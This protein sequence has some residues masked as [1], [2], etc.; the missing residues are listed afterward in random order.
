VYST[1]SRLPFQAGEAASGRIHLSRFRI[2]NAPDPPNPTAI[3]QAPS[4]PARTLRTAGPPP[5]S[6]GANRTFWPATL[7]SAVAPEKTPPSSLKR[8]AVAIVGTTADPCE[9]TRREVSGQT[10]E[11]T[12]LQHVPSNECIAEASRH[13]VAVP[14]L[15]EARTS[16]G[17]CLSA[18]PSSRRGH[19][20]HAPLEGVG[21]APPR[22]RAAKHASGRGL[23]EGLEKAMEKVPFPPCTG[24]SPGNAPRAKPGGSPAHIREAGNKE[25]RFHAPRLRVADVWWF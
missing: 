9:A 16:G 25:V 20:P 6:I 14:P 10:R 24:A 13:L 21:P 8:D 15:A 12:D 2:F 5:T 22:E 19:T 3:P 1:W 7:P 11:H 4:H 18:C 17:P 23:G